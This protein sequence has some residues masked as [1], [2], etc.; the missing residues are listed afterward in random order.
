M[1][2]NSS[3]TIFDGKI[4]KFRIITN[5]LCYGPCPEPEEEVEQHLIIA[6][7]GRVWFTGY[8]FGEYGIDKYVQGRKKHFKLSEEKIKPIFDAFQ[9]YFSTWFMP[10]FVTDV[11]D[12]EM[13]ITTDTG[14]VVK[15]SSSYGSEML[16][17]DKHLT[18]IV[19]EILE[20]EDLWVFGGIEE[21][22]E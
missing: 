15:F 4:Q 3:E 18:Q 2:R 10:C 22:E 14:N 9:E 11:G 17:N 19:T 5:G 6:R 16:Y 1:P 21:Y 13:T 7:D 12:W 8:N 20:I